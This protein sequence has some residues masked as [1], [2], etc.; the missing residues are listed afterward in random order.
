MGKSAEPPPAFARCARWAALLF[1]LASGMALLAAA[2][3]ASRES[4]EARA[5]AREANAACAACHAEAEQELEASRHHGGLRHAI[6]CLGCHFPHGSGRAAPGGERAHP[7]VA[8]DV[9]AATVGGAELGP[10]GIKTSC[11]DCHQEAVAEFHL[12]FAHPLGNAVRCTSCHPPHGLSS[13][14]AKRYVR[15]EACVECHAEKRGPFVF[16][17]EADR[18]ER[19]VTCH[20]PHGSPN[21]RLLTHADSSRLCFSCHQGLPDHVQ[22]PGSIFR[23]CLS[24]K[25]EVHGSNWSDALLR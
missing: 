15:E 25:T 14:E 21:R 6:G 20:E 17:H 19:C 9:A 11:A 16:P 22:S 8:S 23:K 5:A 1:P 3:A 2:C 13:L 4:I 12:P 10:S 24:C 18:V 7:D